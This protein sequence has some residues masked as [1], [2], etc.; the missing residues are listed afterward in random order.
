[1][2]YF[3]YRVLSMYILYTQIA[4]KTHSF[5]EAQ[6]LLAYCQNIHKYADSLLFITQ[7]KTIPHTSFRNRLDPCGKREIMCL[8]TLLDYT[9]CTCIHTHTH[10]H[11]GICAHTTHSIHSEC[12]SVCI[13][14][15]ACCL[16]LIPL[17]LLSIVS[18]KDFA[19]H[20]Y[21]LCNT[22]CSRYNTEWMCHSLNYIEEIDCSTYTRYVHFW[23][24]E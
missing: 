21:L 3:L 15:C 18:S 1:M 13:V 23:N 20:V 8:S 10:S 6:N 22:V 17:R 12:V 7:R 9:M 19:T 11:L 4:Q 5:D 24:R 2:Y 16:L 14:S